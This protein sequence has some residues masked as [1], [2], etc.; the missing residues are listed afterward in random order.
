MEPASDSGPLNKKRAREGL[1][2]SDGS[3]ED[4][5]SNQSRLETPRQRGNTRPATFKACNECRQQKVSAKIVTLLV[6]IEVLIFLF[7][8]CLSSEGQKL[9]YNSFVVTL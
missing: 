8:F 6:K 1:A 4:P 7:Y 2:S 5:L 3:D 9:T